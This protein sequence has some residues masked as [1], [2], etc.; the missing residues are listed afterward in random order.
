M[1]ASSATWPLSGTEII[2]TKLLPV[3]Y[4]QFNTYLEQIISMIHIFCTQAKAEILVLL[5]KLWWWN[6]DLCSS[7]KPLLC[8]CLSHWIHPN[9]STKTLILPQCG[10]L[11]EWSAASRIYRRGKVGILEAART[12]K[13]ERM[14]FWPYHSLGLSL[15]TTS[16]SLGP[17][18]LTF[19]EGVV[20][21]H[22]R[23]LFSSDC[24]AQLAPRVCRFFLLLLL[25]NSQPCLHLSHVA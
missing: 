7:I 14:A 1:T 11:P 13:S 3:L 21:P 12:L 15:W 4:F 17:A 23:I 10:S 24:D 16:F 22:C 18:V 19:H 2:L 6:K 8:L 20:Y 9:L 25:R 5:D